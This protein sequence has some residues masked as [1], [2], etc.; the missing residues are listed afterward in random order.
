MK[1]YGFI[2]FTA[3]ILI[4]G[5]YFFIKKHDYRITF[6]TKQAP[7]IVYSNLIGWNNWELKK[8]KAVVTISKTPFSRLSQELKISDSI[9]EIDWFIE[10]KNDS[11]T[12]VTALIKDKENSLV[13][14]IKV[15][16][17]KTDFVK[18]SLTTVK[19]IKKGLETFEETY[20]V[21]KIEKDTIP[22]QY[23]AYVSVESKLFDKANA[24]IKYN[25]FV[26]EY[27]AKNEVKLTGKPFLEVTNWNLEEDLINFNFCFPIPKKE[28]YSKSNEIK[29]KSTEKREALKVTFNGNYRISDKAWFTIIDYAERNNIE[30]EKLPTE[31]FYNNPHEGGNSIDW[32]AE[33]YMPLKK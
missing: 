12:K 11:I 22:E 8:N 15:P 32:V 20:R 13:Q 6:Q 30:I 17:L 2:F 4:F 24:M 21:S 18:R 5:W 28:F 29:I 7:G 19:K 26:M 3:L 23:C 33:I 27:I 1:K 9:F 25:G 31:I 14:K 16:F 10:R